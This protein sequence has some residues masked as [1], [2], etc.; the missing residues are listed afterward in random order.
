MS[1]QDYVHKIVDFLTLTRMLDVWHPQ[2]MSFIPSLASGHRSAMMEEISRNLSAAERAV[3]H[4][5]LMDQ[6]KMENTIWLSDPA[7]WTP[8]HDEISLRL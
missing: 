5:L 6:I 8:R 7:E 4:Q 3:R 1:F 2:G